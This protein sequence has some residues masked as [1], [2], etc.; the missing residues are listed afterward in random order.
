MMELGVEYPKL[1]SLEEEGEGEGEGLSSV[2][3]NLNY[4]FLC[5]VFNNE[6][7]TLVNI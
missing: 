6:K 1:R 7:Y 4:S 2:P 3:A 5:Y